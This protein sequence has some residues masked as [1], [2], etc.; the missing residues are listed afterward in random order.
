MIAKR[1]LPLPL[2]L[3][4]LMVVFTTL[5]L[6]GNAN[7]TSKAEFKEVEWDELVP[8]HWRP[9][10]EL[11]KL[12][13][14]GKVGDDDPRVIEARRKLEMPVQPANKAL[15]G[16]KIKIAGFV[17]PLDY[18]E[19]KVKEFLLLPYHGACIHVPPPPTNQTVFVK[20]GKEGVSIRGMF[21][22]VWISG[23]I[24]IETVE[25]DLAEAGYTLYAEKVE[26]YE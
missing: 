10:P 3:A 8:P 5:G 16:E 15:D 17:L 19:E 13:Q 24:K 14:E 4:L 2:S 20:T 21:A 25:S 18:T 23:V 9:D 1:S 26:P 6:I 22:T 7:A 12:Y 11:V